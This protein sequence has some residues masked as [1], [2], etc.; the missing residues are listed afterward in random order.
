MGNQFPV[1]SAAVQYIQ[2]HTSKTEE[3]EPFYE[4]VT[5]RTQA[6]ADVYAGAHIAH[7]IFHPDA[8]TIDVVSSTVFAVSG[9]WDG[10]HTTPALYVKMYQD[11]ALMSA[12]YDWYTAY[13]EEML[14]LY[15]GQMH[16]EEGHRRLAYA[17]DVRVYPL[18]PIPLYK[19]L[20]HKGDEPDSIIRSSIGGG[21]H[22]FLEW[23]LG[24]NEWVKLTETRCE[25]WLHQPVSPRQLTGVVAKRTLW[26]FL[27]AISKEDLINLQ[28]SVAA[29]ARTDTGWEDGT[30]WRETRTLVGFLMECVRGQLPPGGS[31]RVG[32]DV[33][34]PVERDAGDGAKI[35][36]YHRT[37]LFEA[38]EQMVEY[39][40]KYRLDSGWWE[41]NPSDG[42]D[43]LTNLEGWGFSQEAVDAIQ[44]TWPSESLE[45]RIKYLRAPYLA[46]RKRYLGMRRPGMSFAAWLDRANT[47]T[48][49]NYMYG[50]FGLS[51]QHYTPKEDIIIY[52]AAF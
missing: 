30:L 7:I 23:K 44:D 29:L 5:M 12:R 43:D 19:K 3:K 40:E 35:Y 32:D 9:N 27:Y 4:E 6:D 16:Q 28:K 39:P 18:S 50:P 10:R 47:T 52:N 41:K 45:E 17:T 2:D 1:R 20:N 42:D 51:E 11:P 13:W 15:I 26:S 22:I 24:T 38:V 31:L 34:S 49:P 36:Y 21:A 14:T 37:D 48:I 25:K 8:D 33:W 46:V